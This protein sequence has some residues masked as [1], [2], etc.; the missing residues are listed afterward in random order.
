LPANQSSEVLKKDSVTG[1]LM[2]KT[3]LDDVSGVV[4]PGEVLAIMGPSGFATTIHSSTC[5]NTQRQ[6][7]QDNVARLACWAREQR[8]D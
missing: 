4:N 8:R 1:K 6:I 3:I 7:R 2:T 5:S